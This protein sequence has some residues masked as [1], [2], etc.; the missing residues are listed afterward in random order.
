MSTSSLVPAFA[1]LGD[2][3][4]WSILTRLATAPAS[5]SRLAD[6]FPISRQAILK[7]L[8]IL[9]DVGLVKTHRQGREVLYSPIGAELSALGH[10][11]SRVADAWDRRLAKLKALAES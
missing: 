2:E 3:T 7:H 6:E 4:R 8:E 1:A 5:A 9:R 10:Q 11:L